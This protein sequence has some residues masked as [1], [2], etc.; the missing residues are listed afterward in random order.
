MCWSDGIDWSATGDFWAGIGSLAVGAATIFLALYAK[1]GLTAWKSQQL[2]IKRLDLAQDM[3]A[4]VFT[5]EETLKFIV[6]P[7]VGAAELDAV[8]R[9]DGETDRDYDL[10]K[11][12]D[13]VIK[14]YENHTDFFSKI[15]AL[16]FRA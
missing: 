5:A 1:R 11:T 14:R 7:F 15:R 12:Y 8:E 16:A 3:L 10:R 4:E 2:G 6:S 9:L 13:A